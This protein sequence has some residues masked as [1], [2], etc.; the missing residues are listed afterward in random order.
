VLAHRSPT[1]DCAYPC[2]IHLRTITSIQQHIQ[3]CRTCSQRLS[4]NKLNNRFQPCAVEFGGRDS[5]KSMSFQSQYYH[6]CRFASSHH[7][8]SMEEKCCQEA[9]YQ[10][11]YSKEEL[12]E[13]P[14]PNLDSGIRATPDAQPPRYRRCRTPGRSRIIFS[15]EE[16]LQETYD[17]GYQTRLFGPEDIEGG[18]CQP[19]AGHPHIHQVR[20]GELEVF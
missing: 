1:P 4:S 5:I 17:E 16:S 3:V 15:N 10:K 12:R 9:C 19:G 7:T 11:P 13:C 6:D 14:D 8:V 20:H 2:T 18:T